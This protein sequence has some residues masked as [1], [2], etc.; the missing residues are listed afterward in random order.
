MELVEVKLRGMGSLL[1]FKA[2]DCR[3]DELSYSV[4]LGSVE[5]VLWTCEGTLNNSKI[6][7]GI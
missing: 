2:E 1:R 7:N 5:V 6:A 3:Y 4:D